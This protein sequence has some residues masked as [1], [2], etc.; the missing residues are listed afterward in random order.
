MSDITTIQLRFDETSHEGVEVVPLGERRFRL[1]DTPVFATDS[2]FA[3]DVIE[4]A[5]LTD[6]THRFVRVLERAP[7]RHYSWALPRGWSDSPERD[8]Y[9]AQVEAAG[10]TWEQVFGGVLFV[11]IPI[12]SSFDAEAELDRYLKSHSAEA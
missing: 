12:E 3:G 6:G 7:F 2:V 8:T 11:H 1:Q 10:G 4:A 5:P 9:I